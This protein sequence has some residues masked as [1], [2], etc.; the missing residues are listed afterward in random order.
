MYFLTEERRRG[1]SFA[2][3][4]CG[5][6]PLDETMRLRRFP[7]SGLPFRYPSLRPPFNRT[8]VSPN[9]LQT[10]GTVLQAANYT[11]ALA[12]TRM[13]E[14]K[15]VGLHPRLR[16]LPLEYRHALLENG[17]LPAFRDKLG[18]RILTVVRQTIIGTR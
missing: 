15:T 10:T 9:R 1:D 2:R 7:P 17:T 13:C 6:H 11:S 5:K 18:R 8:C 16:E 12:A 14:P 4:G 3:F